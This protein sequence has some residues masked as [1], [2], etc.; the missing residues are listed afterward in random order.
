MIRTIQRASVFLLVLALSLPCYAP[1]QS[2]DAGKGHGASTAVARP[3]P[4]RSER[5][6]QRGK[7]AEAAGRLEDAIAA[8]DQ[9]ARFNPGNRDALE[10]GALLRSRLVHERVDTAEQL[11]LSGSVDKA[12]RELRS[13]LRLDSGNASV[14]ERLGQIAAMGQAPAASATP[15][16]AQAETRF[17]GIPRLRPLAGKRSFDLR[18]DTQ[19]AYQQVAQS[20]GLKVLFDA[21]LPSR[22]V[23]LRVSEVDFSTAIAILASQTRTFLRPLRADTFFVA[24]DTQAK[25]REYELRVEQTFPL[26]A[27]V[28]PEEMT[29]LLRVLR[30][31]TGTTHITLDPRSRIVTINDAPR[32]VALAGDLIRQ[33]EQ[34]PGE[35]M[36]DIELLEVNRSEALKLGVTP[37]S[38]ARVL[39]LSS[40]DVE[41]LQQATDLNSLVTKLQQI[42][43]TQG[44]SSIPPFILVGGGKTTFALTMPGATVDFSQALS[45]VRSGRRIL[46]RAQDRKPASFFVGDRFPVTLSLLSASLGVSSLTG[47]VSSTVF[48]RTDFDV[49]Q[50]PLA[51]V[52]NNFGGDTLRDLAVVNHNDNP[53]TITILLNQGNGNF[54]PAPGSPIVLGAT[55]TGASAIASADVNGDGFA[56]L[57]ITN[58]TSSNVTLLFGNG[59]GTFTAAAGSP[60]TVGAGPSAVVIADF[61]GDNKLDFAVANNTDNSISVFQGDGIGGFTPFANSPFV[62]PNIVAGSE[63]GPVAMVTGDFRND[64]KPGLAVVNQ[65]SNTVS[66][67]LGSG[68]S[69]F[70][71]TFSEA[72]NSPTQVG[73]SP[74]AIAAG[75]L[76]GDA[77]AD[78]AVVNQGAGSLTILL[79]NGDATFTQ[80][81]GSPLA[82][83]A[84]PAG[85]A[86]A[87]FTR[88]GVNDLAVTNQGPSTLGLY[89][90]LGS[91]TF[92]NRFELNTTAGPRAIVASDLN[93]DSL[94]DVALTAETANKVSVFLAPS[95]L[96]STAATLQQPYPA[97]E[98]VDLGIKVKATPALHSNGEVTLHLEFEI[99]ALS[100]RNANGIP[101]FSNRT[102]SQTVR[103]RENETSLI[104]GLLDRDETSSLTGL[105]GFANVPGAGFLAGRH[106]KT[107]TETELVILVTPRQLRLPSRISKSI[108]AG[109]GHGRD[110]PQGE[111]S[112][113]T[114]EP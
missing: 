36:L 97:S 112:P 17:A 106:S 54:I 42:L 72:T 80:P 21:D 74:V 69:T 6:L 30:D 48:P 87:D 16:P 92:A 85:I 49:G 41:A 11:A 13:A 99:R 46:L 89:L 113:A 38:S 109:R 111:G 53:N 59:D 1:A 73:N 40:K 108:Y 105:P 23:R 100:G 3:D 5:L 35:L 56:D 4:R 31:I 70:D 76:D 43:A 63:L 96:A 103:I 19:A 84:T 39:T 91:G 37:P 58:Q 82:T 20:F 28:G 9:A 25:R 75:D 14:A 52:A 95:S 94:P 101:I 61:N 18:G 110:V 68:D 77:V 83:A 50:A 88:D 29:E 104:G 15:D 22:Q 79:N 98:Y 107:P 62:L 93:G 78:L 60:F 102:I 27:S 47:T 26:P 114:V 55:E 7:Q 8:Y 34:A 51:L 86:I 90:G 2:P 57:L 71:G 12:T 81:T 64:G 66:L 33:L 10:R 24:A 45:L 32:I 44:L 65:N 67:L